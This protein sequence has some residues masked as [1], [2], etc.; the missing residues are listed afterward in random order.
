MTHTIGKIILVY[1]FWTVK[2]VVEISDTCPPGIHKR[3][4][5]KAGAL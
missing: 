2:L 5:P 3:F 1:D 4:E